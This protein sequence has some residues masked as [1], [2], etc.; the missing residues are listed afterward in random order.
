MNAQVEDLSSM[1][2]ERLSANQPAPCG[3]HGDKPSELFCPAHGAAICHLCASSEHRACPDVTL[4]DKRVQELRAELS[5]M[6]A[7]L[8]AAE[9]KLDGA[10]GR[11]DRQLEEA[12]AATTTSLAQ[13]D[14][15]CDRLEKAVKECRRRLKEVWAWVGLGCGGLGWGGVG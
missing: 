14:A 11:L 7:D 5:C 10:M 13:I 9:V 8:R 1:T 15:A 2:A 3:A 12:E 4:F 6:S